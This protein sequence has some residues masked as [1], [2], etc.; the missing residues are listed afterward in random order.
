MTR[1]EHDLHPRDLSGY[2]LVMDPARRQQL[3]VIGFIPAA[4]L[5]DLGQ[6]GQVEAAIQVEL[7]SSWDKGKYRVVGTMQG[8]ILLTCSRCLELYPFP[9]DLSVDRLFAQGYDPAN[10]VGEREIID[11]VDYLPDSL[12]SVRHMV[13]EELLLCLPMTPLCQEA[14]AGICPECGAELNQE[15]CHCPPAEADH[16]FAAL[17][18]LNNERLK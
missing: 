13:E 8:R 1:E 16:P 4:S 6:S 5:L 7:T 10:T 9:L 15:F 14:C 3:R 2:R 12:I 11:V 17:Q 18:C